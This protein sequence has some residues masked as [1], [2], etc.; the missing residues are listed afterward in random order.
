M[1]FVFPI[2]MAEGHLVLPMSVRV[3]VHPS[4]G[5]VWPITLNR[6][7]FDNEISRVCISYQ[8]DVSRPKKQLSHIY[9]FSNLP[10][11]GVRVRILTPQSYGLWP[12]KL[13]R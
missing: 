8:D 12:M 7:E 11:P 2:R 10:F 6:T 3:S 1:H 5:G 13:H 9:F 4:V